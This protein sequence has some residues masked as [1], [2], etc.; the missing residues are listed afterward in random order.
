MILAVAIVA[1]AAVAIVG[2]AYAYTAST[3]NTANTSASEYII[4]K[5]VGGDGTEAAADYT[6]IFNGTIKYDTV[7]NGLNTTTYT[8]NADQKQ[9]YGTFSGVLLGTQTINIERV[10]ST[11]DTLIFSVANK[12]AD[13]MTGDFVIGISIDGGSNYTYRTF[14]T[15]VDTK[16]YYDTT[17]TAGATATNVSNAAAISHTVTSIKVQMIVTN[18]TATDQ[19]G[20]I[21]AP[22]N[23]VTFEFKAEIPEPQA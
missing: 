20:N 10:S 13:A 4:L 2:A 1:V 11:A 19:S 9:T 22:L 23:T 8:F 15:T 12:T 17:T 6:G 21:V 14:T 5:Q 18:F 3:Q 7:H 16:N